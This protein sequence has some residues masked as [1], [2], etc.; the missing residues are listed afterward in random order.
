MALANAWIK[1]NESLGL[2]ENGQLM[3]VAFYSSLMTVLF[4]VLFFHPLF[5]SGRSPRVLLTLSMIFAMF[6]VEGTFSGD[7][8][9]IAFGIIVSQVVFC[10]GVLVALQETVR[11]PSHHRSEECDADLDERVVR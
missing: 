3:P 6:A 8:Q 2:T 10:S 9:Q 11:K 7:G 5:N 4:G 1:T